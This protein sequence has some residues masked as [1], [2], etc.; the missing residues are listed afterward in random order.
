MD[1][2]LIEKLMAMLSQSD[3]SELEVTEG[4][5]HVRLSKGPTGSPPPTD[6]PVRLEDAAV[7]VPNLPEG[8]FTVRAGT[9]GTY[10]CAPSPGAM[11]FVTAGQRIEEGQTLGLIEAM[12]MLNP[13][14]AEHSGTLVAILVHDGDPVQPGQVLFQI[15]GA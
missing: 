4:N 15:A 8:S 2:G 3:L 13:V 11:P 6:A 1:I 14:E 12:K 9:S 10:Y 7:A 5:L